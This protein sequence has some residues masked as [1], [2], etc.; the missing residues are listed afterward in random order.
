MS[1]NPEKIDSEKATVRVGILHS[2]SGT[3][4]I[5]EK[6][7]KDAELMAIAEINDSGGVLGRNL[8]PILEDAQSKPAQF[9]S[10]ARKLLEIDKVATVFGCWTSASR[11]AVLPVF[12]ELN[13]LLWYPLQYEGLES[14]PN[15]FYTGLC[16]NQQVEPAVNWLL[17]NKGNKF[18]LLGSDYVFPRT[19]NKIIKSQLKQQGGTVLNEEYVPL[20]ET[21]FHLTIEKIQQC[22]PDVVFSTING[23]SNLAFY[24]QYK[25][26]GISAAEIPILATSVAEEELQK[27]GEI[28]A[29]HY[30]SWTYFQELD[31]PQNIIFVEEFKARY[32]SDRVTSDPIESAY[33]QVYLWKLA[34]EKAGSFDTEKVRQAAINLTYEAPGGLVK[35]E[36]NQHLWKRCRIGQIMPNGQFQEVWSAEDLIKPQPW[37]GIEDLDSEAVPLAID[38]LAEMPGAIQRSCEVE[39]KSQELAATMAELKAANRRLQI[40]QDLL[41]ESESRIHR[42]TQREEMMK[43]QLSSKIHSSLELNTIVSTAV[44]E[45][46]NLLEIDR[47]KF[48]WYQPDIETSKFELLYEVSAPD[49]SPKTNSNSCQLSQEAVQAIKILEEAIEEMNSVGWDE[50]L[51]SFHIDELIEEYLSTLGLTSVM[52]VPVQI[53]GAEIGVI[54]CEHCTE[55][56]AW[57]QHEMDMLQ[58]IA[59]QLAVA[60]DRAKLYERSRLNASFASFQSEQL[61]KTL[62]D[63]QKTQSQLIQTE[64]MS[65]L[66]QLVA[67][68]AHEIN[69]PINFIFG[70]VNYAKHY[71]EDLLEHL[72]LYQKYYPETP[73]EIAE[74]NEASEIDF[75]VED[76]PNIL[77][78]MAKGAERI[79]KIVDSLRNFSRLDE[80]EVKPVNIHDGIESTLMMLQHR[81][82]QS[83]I[84]EEIKIIKEY[85]DLPK[86][87]CC[88]GQLNQVFMNI[89]N[90]AID[91]IESENLRRSPPEILDNPSTITIRTTAGDRDF[92]TI[93]IIDSGPGMTE[94]VRARLFDPFFTTKPVGK[95]TGL[96]LSVA[97]QIV[98]EKH[99]GDILCS[100]KPSVGTEFEIKIPISPSR[101][102]LAE[103][104]HEIISP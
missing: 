91:A 72:E 26:A 8:E 103:N 95:G 32:G 78:S 93:K 89:L 85:D 17:E 64:K 69:N 6:S 62:F 48:M 23:E 66:G 3:M 102:S 45:I 7:L 77:S 11:K 74:H 39:Q 104:T 37:L 34:V 68:I 56:Y 76:L 73:S 96:G 67:G 98:V 4:A 86:I 16:P 44:E 5:G 55:G 2:L 84:K 18:Y 33:S 15:I 41:L 70:N 43:R 1:D 22:R 53:N 21:D 10:K 27:I 101:R 97:Y 58:D 12:E 79:G 83:T 24:R 38:M 87:E 65:A 19:V 40:T 63:L 92:V 25:E 42:L 54:V 47:C 81:L 57:S 94:D 46:R 36:K 9:A 14:S 99:G 80:A 61:K 52:V 49:L 60:I 59:Q 75:L 88:A 20:G 31:T 82:N 51:K 71:V 50:N 28:A 29:G 100:S 30:G 13:S 35:I 90:N